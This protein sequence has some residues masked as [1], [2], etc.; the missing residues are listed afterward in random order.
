MSSS[1]LLD[2]GKN[3][4]KSLLFLDP[5]Q[6]ET[7][8]EDDNYQTSQFECRASVEKDAAMK[9]TRFLK[10]ENSYSCKGFN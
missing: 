8:D 3:F 6:S 4:A 2:V 5:N 1:M 7:N 10:I 9:I